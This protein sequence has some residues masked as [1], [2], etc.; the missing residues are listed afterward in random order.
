VY[1]LLAALPMVGFMR[2]RHTGPGPDLSTTLRWI[3]L[4][5]DGRAATLT[6]IHRAH[7]IAT[8]AARYAVHE[9]EAPPFDSDWWELLAP[10]ATM[11]VRGWIPLLFYGAD[12]ELAPTAV[13]DVYQVRQVDGWRRPFRV[14]TRDL[15][16]DQPW[17]GDPLVAADLERGL[18]GSFFTQ[19]EPDF[20][21]SDWL[22][23]ELVS[24]G[25]DGSFDS[26]DD[27]RLVS[28]IAV[29]L[30]LSLSHSPTELERRLERAYLRG[31]HLFYITG[32]RWDLIDARILAE[33]RLVTLS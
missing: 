13:R 12:S 27:L 16:R 2:L 21:D 32:S 19:E 28:Y 11:H 8:A 26:A 14:A 5:D 20:A 18:W 25:A 10:Y 33:F 9:L 30:T 7:E 4:G 17:H 3:A 1:G 29:G 24:A 6:T 22:R 31:H 23:L 15:P